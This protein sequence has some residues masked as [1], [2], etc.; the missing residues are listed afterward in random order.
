MKRINIVY[1]L[2][3]LC[4][5][6]FS[7]NSF[8]LTYFRGRTAGF[9]DTFE[10][11]EMNLLSIGSTILN[12]KTGQAF[13]IITKVD[14][15]GNLILDT[16]FI[17]Q[18][19][20]LTFTYG[21]QKANGNYM[22]IGTGAAFVEFHKEDI[23]YFCELSPDFDIVWE[24]F[25][26]IPEPYRSHRML[27]FV[28]EP[29]SSILIMGKADSTYDSFDDNLFIARVTN[30]GD[31][32]QFRFY[33]G[34]QTGG[35]YDC[36]TP[37]FDSTG[38]QLIGL[39]GENSFLREWIELDENLEITN[40]IP[41][42]DIEHF[43]NG[44]TTARWL[45]NGNIISITQDATNFNPTPDIY[46]KI[47]DSNFDIVNDTIM[48]YDIRHTPPYM[49]AMDFTDED[50]IW[51][52]SCEWHWVPNCC[53]ESFYLYLFDSNG[54]LKGV[55]EYGGDFPYLMYN[56]RATSDGGC[57]LTGSKYNP[58]GSDTLNGYMIKVMPEDVISAMQEKPA[59]K[60]E[61]SIYPSPFSDYLY[62]NSYG[63]EILFRLFDNTGKEVLSKKVRGS[64]SLPTEILM[65]GLYYYIITDNE[66][67]IQNGKLIKTK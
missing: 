56:I 55:K 14:I 37:N 10:D 66:T 21:Y 16:V 19:T 48:D 51:M 65:S 8:D 35:V 59:G 26:K 13:P 47:M 24:K 22:L 32:S 45:S 42:L 9:T 64:T 20:S 15:E 12:S 31:V 2:V 57:V 29:D 23:S 4:L 58:V 60:K 7:Q 63:K 18:D 50:N 30:N 53:P 39:Y 25:Y 38:Y 40:Y 49:N 54:N 28:H 46:V 44:S 33:D 27:N 6:L 67:L 5:H 11:G 41:W 43:F 52:A 36:F 34:W 17:K 62:C 61:I 3:L 1:I